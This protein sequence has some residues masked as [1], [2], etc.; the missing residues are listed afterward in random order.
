[1][2]IR[3][4]IKKIRERYD[5]TQQELAEIAGVT[6]K[7]VWAWENGLS[8]PRMGAIEK[9]ANR[10]GIRKGNIVDEG[11]M[12]RL[13]EESTIA[14]HHDGEEWTE[15]ELEEIERFKEFLRMKKKD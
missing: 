1:L 7:A 5:L 10:F 9:I 4:N 15:E 2:S 3:G 11:G 8:E 6:N 13:E 12:D 14:A